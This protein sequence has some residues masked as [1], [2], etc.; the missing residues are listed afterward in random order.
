MHPLRLALVSIGAVLLAGCSYVAS[1]GFLKRDVEREGAMKELQNVQIIDVTEP[2]ALT[3][4]AKRTSHLF[5]ETF[6]NDPIDTPRVGP[7]DVLEVSILEAPPASLFGATLDARGVSTTSHMITLPEQVVSRDGQ[8]VVPFVGAVTASGR[9]LPQIEADI[10]HGLNGRANDPQVLVRLM[11]NATSS[12]TVVGEVANSTQ[13]P[14]TPRGEHLLDALAAAGGVRQ[15]VAKMTIQMTRGDKTQ[16]LPLEAI[17]RDPK[18]NVPL[19][20]GD[21]VT[22]IFAPLSFTA[23]GS[24]GKN[25]EI[26]FEAQ[27][28]SLAQ[29]LA[30]AGGLLDNQADARGVYIF[31][32]EPK[33]AL[34]WPNE[35][36]ATTRDGRVP[37][38]Y[39]LDMKNPTSLFVAQ[40]F[41]M[42]N[43]DLM[44]VS[45]APATQIQKFLN[46]LFTGLYPVLSAK[47]T[48][49][50]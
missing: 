5:S 44:Y 10:A 3:L 47:Q 16:A 24:T 13:V 4:Q 18:Q 49:G 12:A 34:P 9:S 33:D 31:R 27:G 26:N 17:I 46:L 29:A 42:S 25:E 7:G 37:V 45:S 48:F 19:H 32:F 38:V 22:A 23:L 28:I 8:I 39:R 20:P 11:R 35:P 14:I 6:G 40:D 2:I 50:F 41:P 30:R 36:V 15:P 21:V 43:N 1:S